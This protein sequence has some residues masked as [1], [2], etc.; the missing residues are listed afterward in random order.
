MPT[1]DKELKLKLDELVEQ[2][3]ASGSDPARTQSLEL[4]TIIETG[5]IQL[6]KYDDYLVN[7]FYRAPVNIL[8]AQISLAMLVVV[9]ILALAAVRLGTDFSGV[10]F[11]LVIGV[12][13]ALPY[14]FIF[15]VLKTVRQEQLFLIVTAASFIYSLFLALSFA[16]ISTTIGLLGV[17]LIPVLIL[18]FYAL[19]IKKLIHLF[20]KNTK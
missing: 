19:E 18:I 20:N 8:R 14:I 17:I 7:H 4:K 6:K 9:I 1:R 11:F 2:E 5:N 10:L 3:F 15:F 12:V 13:L 16:L